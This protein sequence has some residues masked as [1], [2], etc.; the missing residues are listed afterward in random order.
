MPNTYGK[1]D[2]AYGQHGKLG[3]SNHPKG[4]ASVKK[5]LKLGLPLNWSK[6]QK[7]KGHDVN[8]S[9]ISRT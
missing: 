6:K 3:A 4:A 7:K 5:L 2:K 9:D 8:G 1:T